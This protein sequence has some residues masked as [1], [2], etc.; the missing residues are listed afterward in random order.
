MAEVSFAM[1]EQKEIIPVL[2]RLCRIPFRL[3]R[4]EYIDLTNEENYSRRIEELVQIMSMQEPPG[5]LAPPAVYEAPPVAPDLPV[6][7]RTHIARDPPVVV[8]KPVAPPPPP[9]IQ[10]PIA[11]VGP[12]VEE[13]WPAERRFKL[14]STEHAPQAQE[15]APA[16]KPTRPPANFFKSTWGKVGIAAA[17]VTVLILGI[18]LATSKPA[19]SET[20]PPGASQTAPAAPA[21]PPVDTRLVGTWTGQIDNEPAN[22]EFTQDPNGIQ[23]SVYYDASHD[24]KSPDHISEVLSVTQNQDQV[25]LT[26]TSY[27]DLD[28]RNLNFKLDTME[29]KLSTDGTKFAGNIDDPYGN[30]APIEFTK[31]Q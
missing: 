9:I 13:S 1:D 14:P 27:Q 8:A 30:L 15:P 17:V 25:T 31:S 3:R 6:V 12:V 10:R 26:G 16:L 20:T 2:Y 23:G 29:V 28:N 24:P 22:M 11:P 18:Y 19:T 21:A 7:V 4:I 5:H